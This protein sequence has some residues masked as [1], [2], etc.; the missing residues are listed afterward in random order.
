LNRK[1]KAPRTV[2]HEIDKNL[3]LARVAGG[4]EWDGKLSIP[5]AL[6]AAS[7]V[8]RWLEETGARS[9]VAVHAGTSNPEKKW[10]S[11]KFAELCGR[12]ASGTGMKVILIGGPEEKI[13]S[14]EVAR[15][16]PAGTL[17]WTGKLSLKELAAFFA[18]P[19]VKALVSSDSGPAHVAWITGKPAVVLFAKNAVGSDPAKWGPRDGGRSEVLFKNM[20]EIAVDEVYS[21]L[22]RVLSKG[23]TS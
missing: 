21:A 18:D 15:L 2:R 9:V 10:A 20:P 1:L 8:A 5:V 19:R 11:V 3:D 16:A 17:D 4:A 6:H 13:A 22:E 12:I 7:N 14:A 23:T